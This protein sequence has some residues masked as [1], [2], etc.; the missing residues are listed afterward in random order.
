[1]QTILIP[2]DFSATAQNAANYAIGLG[3][4]LM[5]NKIVLLHC[6]QPIMVGDPIWSAPIADLNTDKEL[7]EA[8][9]A[10]EKKR[11]QYLSPIHVEINTAFTTGSLV[12]AV[13]EY[14]KNNQVH[15]IV[16]G[17][18]GGD[19]LTEKLIGSN[20]LNLANEIKIPLVIVPAKAVYSFIDHVL[21]LSDFKDTNATLP[22]KTME[23]VLSYLRPKISVVH[24]DP[25]YN[26][27]TE[28]MQREKLA[29]DKMIE[30]YTR[31]YHYFVRPDL[32]D[33]VNEFCDIN[34][35]QLMIMIPKKHNWF[36]RLF[37]ASHTK[38]MAFHANIPLLI[39]HN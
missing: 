24:F 19:L 38:A 31:N 14:C 26:R 28:N 9:L 1:M 35:I 25:A 36:E 15:C 32:E 5:V 34:K 29:L 16:M 2:T 12:H 4:Q 6:W 27:D 8:Q 33:A 20:A 7:I 21:L 3:K 30:E 39:V 18:T 10:A 13:E 37:S 23:A 22:A 11:L 17:I